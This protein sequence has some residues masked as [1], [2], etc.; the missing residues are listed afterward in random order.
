M[1][2]NMKVVL[3]MIL[4]II[5]FAILV[6]FA[7]NSVQNKAITLEEQIKVSESDVEVQEKRREDLV[8]NLVDTVKQYDKYEAETLKSIVESR[9][10][11]APKE[12]STVLSAVSEAY[13]QLKSNT[14][15]KQLML[16]LSIT[17]NKISEHRTTYNT[18]VKEYNR[19][20]KKFP[21]KQILNFMGYQKADYT[22]LEFNSKSDAPQNLFKE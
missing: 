7:L 8:F 20:I 2:K 9:K 17:E 22:Y 1:F 14:N 6:V 3:S 4:G 11:N 21:N 13:P 15:Y 18:Q 10:G 5:L 19:F 12:V 16:E